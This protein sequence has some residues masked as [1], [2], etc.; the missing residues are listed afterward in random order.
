MIACERVAIRQLLAGCRP[1]G[2]GH[3]DEMFWSGAMRSDGK[4]SRD[5]ATRYE[6][7]LI[8]SIRRNAPLLAAFLLGRT[9]IYAPLH[10]VGDLAS[11]GDAE[12]E[13]LDL[14]VPVERLFVSGRGDLVDVVLRQ[15]RH[16]A[17]R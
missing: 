3:D 17:P 14:A 10:D 5:F 11:R 2:P 15:L 12:A 16:A 4:V 9:A 7:A 8:F 1:T 6:T 13:A